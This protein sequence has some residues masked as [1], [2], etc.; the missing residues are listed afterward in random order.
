MSKGFRVSKTLVQALFTF[1]LNQKASAV[2]IREY[3]TFISCY[4]LY[5]IVCASL[6]CISLKSVLL[7]YHRCSPDPD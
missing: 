1:I 6:K 7:K 2:H 5:F 4:M 3:T